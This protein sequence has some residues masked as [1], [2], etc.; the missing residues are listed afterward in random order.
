MKSRENQ[1]QFGRRVGNFASATLISRILGY[2]RDSLVAAYFGGG[3]QT[4]A[5]YAAIKIPNLFRRFL[6]EGSLTAAFVPVFT[7][8]LHKKGKEEAS[9]LFSSVF[10]GLTIILSIVVVLGMIFAPQVTRLVSWGFVNDPEKF[11]LT[12][13][14]T[15]LCFPFLLLICLAALV[16]AVLHSCGRFFIPA[17]SPSGLSIGEISFIVFFASRMSHPIEGLAISAV[18]G[19]GIH[20]LWQVPSLIREGFFLRFS[21]PFSHPEVKKIFLLMIPT[22]IGLCADQVNSFVD[23]FCASFLREGSISAL[24]NSNRVMQLPLALFGVTVS[25][26][27]LPALSRS[28]AENNSAE[29][30]DIITHSLRL[31][32]FVL[33]PSCIGLAVLGFP[34]VQ[35]L[36][37]RGQFL[38]ENSVM[39]Y[40]TLVP[41][42]AGLPAY[43]AIKILASAFYAHKNTR[44]P[45]KVAFFAM[46][47]NVI[48][49]VLFMWKWEAAG[50]ALATT[51]SAIYQAC[52]LY[53]FLR[54]EWGP[55]GGKGILKSFVSASGVGLIMGAVCWY[56]GFIVLAH[57]PLAIRVF[58]SISVG[59]VFYFSISKWAK[60]KEVDDFLN[61]LKRKSLTS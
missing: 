25:S 46:G 57:A 18:V 58:L 28:S 34:I 15:R 7:E 54:K 33:I 45:V 12:T 56:V 14:L 37:E 42:V 1:A 51:I 29:F 23:Q 53:Y 43:S 19:V 36:F 26:V 5:F 6:G 3:H 50:L 4:D 27:A 48:L 30:K 11:A 22:V 9:R 60:I 55:S 31:A 20:L 32:N 38:K 21:S 61:I 44:T 13:Q 35:V 39:T 47:L 17:I 16:S 52:A 8:T 2:V 24:Y 49:D 59:C 41:Y 40:A 10:F